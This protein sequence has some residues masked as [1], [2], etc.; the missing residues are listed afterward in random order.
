MHG[1]QYNNGDEWVPF[2]CWVV[3]SRTRLIHSAACDFR[4]GLRILWKLEIDLVA[5]AEARGRICR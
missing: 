4:V 1:F 3:T 2:L 5:I